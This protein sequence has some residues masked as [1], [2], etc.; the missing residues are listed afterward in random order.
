M[1]NKE[2]YTKRSKE[3]EE[4]KKN[5]KKVQ[6]DLNSLVPKSQKKDKVEMVD[7]HMYNGHV[8]WFVLNDDPKMKY[9]M[10]AVKYEAYVNGSLVPLNVSLLEEIHSVFGLLG[11][12]NESFEKNTTRYVFNIEDTVELVDRHIVENDM[13][14]NLWAL[15]FSIRQGS[16]MEE[17]VVMSL[18]EEVGVLERNKEHID[19]NTGELVY[20]FKTEG[21]E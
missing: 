20:S 8:Y 9:A 11:L 10:D 18:L 14:Y 5:S 1:E 19:K 7:V 4:I 13:V 12:L 15:I 16:V 21:Y 6:Y 3:M 2:I 17:P